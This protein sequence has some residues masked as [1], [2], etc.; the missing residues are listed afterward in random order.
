MNDA[1]HDAVVRVENDRAA[2]RILQGKLAEA[3]RRLKRSESALRSAIR[4]DP[5]SWNTMSMV[6]ES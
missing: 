5:A 3:E 1:Q 6:K 2:V 4:G